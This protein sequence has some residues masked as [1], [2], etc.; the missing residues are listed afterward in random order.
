[1]IYLPGF[2]EYLLISLGV[3]AMFSIFDWVVLIIAAVWLGLIIFAIFKTKKFPIDDILKSLSEINSE[4]FLIKQLFRL[5]DKVLGWMKHAGLIDYPVEEE[6]RIEQNHEVF[7]GAQIER[8]SL[9]W[10]DKIRIGVSSLLGFILCGFLWLSVPAFDNIGLYLLPLGFLLGGGT[11]Y[12][13]ITKRKP[14]IK[15]V[16]ILF[17]IGIFLIPICF[18]I[19]ILLYPGS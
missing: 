7:T 10:R 18:G 16:V 13:N 3:G 17:M 2:Q 5:L 9:N 14:G 6:E 11:A 4:L 15:Q 1:M 19:L 8:S 12:Y